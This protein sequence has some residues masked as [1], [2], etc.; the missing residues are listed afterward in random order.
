M[1]M[2]FNLGSRNDFV[3]VEMSGAAISVLLN[4]GTIFIWF[5]RNAERSLVSK[6]L[7]IIS[8]VDSTAEYEREIICNFEDISQFENNGYILISYARKKDKY[9]AVFLVPFSDHRALDNFIESIRQ[10]LEHGEVRMTLSW[11]GGRAR[12]SILYKELSKLNCFSFSNI[13][14]KEDQQRDKTAY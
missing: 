2:D 3:S 14:Y 6:V 12:M 11:D 10:D 9:R 8:R 4:Q 7:L 5:G 1:L 13:T